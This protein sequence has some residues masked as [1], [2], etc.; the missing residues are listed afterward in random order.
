MWYHLCG[1]CVCHWWTV[2]VWRL[3]VRKCLKAER[4]Y[5][6]VHMFIEGTPLNVNVPLMFFLAVKL[7]GEHMDLSLYTSNTAFTEWV[8]SSS[9][10]DISIVSMQPPELNWARRPLVKTFLLAVLG[11]K[12]IST[13]QESGALTVN[14]VTSPR[15]VNAAFPQSVAVISCLLCVWVA[16]T[17]SLDNAVK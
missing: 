9:P 10:L 8:Y 11:V 5:S 3:Y 1:S 7:K 4:F 16:H 17:R 13:T 2:K 14:H 12:V 6:Y 15:Q